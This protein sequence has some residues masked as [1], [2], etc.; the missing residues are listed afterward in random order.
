[1]RIRQAKTEGAMAA[2]AVVRRSIAELCLAD[3]GRD[4]ILLA[5][6]LS[7]KTVENV[8]RRIMQSHFVV[9][10]EAGTILG[11]AAMNDSGKI[12][13]NYVSPDARFRGGSKALV[14]QL[15]AQA[16]AL[17]LSECMLET[18]QTALRFY[19]S[20]GYVKS[21]ETYPLSLTGSPATVLRKNLKPSQI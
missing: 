20:L 1:M 9:A 17:G 4:E 13:L 16:R 21:E 18:T 15:E 12:P 10:E 5:K 6:W 8:T 3:H 2:C 7:N 14:Q 11:V 19:R